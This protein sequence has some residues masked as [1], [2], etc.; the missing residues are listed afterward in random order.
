MKRPDPNGFQK[1]VDQIEASFA[2]GEI[3]PQTRRS[4]LESA[5]DRYGMTNLANRTQ[6][7]P[8]GGKL[9]A[10]NDNQINQQKQ[11]HRARKRGPV[12]A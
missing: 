3:G 11:P 9:V 6:A 1:V 8:P 4:L 2:A 10:M 7:T 12:P 5:R